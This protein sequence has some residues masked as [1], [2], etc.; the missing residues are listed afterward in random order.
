MRLVIG[1]Y[2]V[3]IGDLQRPF[4]VEVQLFGRVFIGQDGVNA[5]LY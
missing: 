1:D 2:A 4:Q 5:R 3:E